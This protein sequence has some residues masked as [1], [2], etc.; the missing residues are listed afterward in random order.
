M[1]PT[2]RN[3]LVVGGALIVVALLLKFTVFGRRIYAVGS[4]EATAR[5]CGIDV[6]TTDGAGS[7]TTSDAFTVAVTETADAAAISANDVSCHSQS[8]SSF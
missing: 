2:T 5:L 3:T 8:V 4:N 6:T 7:Q 1:S